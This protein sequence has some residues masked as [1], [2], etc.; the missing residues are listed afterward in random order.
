MCSKGYIELLF[1]LGGR[2][3]A[4]EPFAVHGPGV[5]PPLVSAFVDSNSLAVS[6]KQ[7]CCSS[8][9]SV[10]LVYFPPPSPHSLSA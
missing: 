8:P 3:M 1:R 2:E 4:K 9:Q 5:F 6:A 7:D 10:V